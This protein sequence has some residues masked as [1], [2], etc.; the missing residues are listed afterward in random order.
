MSDAFWDPTDETL[1]HG[2]PWVTGTQAAFG[3]WAFWLSKL[4]LSSWVL[5]SIYLS[6]CL[7]PLIVFGSLSAGSLIPEVDQSLASGNGLC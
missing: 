1:P 4:P 2:A 5:V 7:G 6:S 3:P